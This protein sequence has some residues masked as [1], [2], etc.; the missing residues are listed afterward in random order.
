MTDAFQPFIRLLKQLVTLTPT[1]ETLIRTL[2]EPISYAK[3]T[4]LVEPGKVASYIYFI[5]D[6]F[7]RAYHYE[8]GNEITNH[9]GAPTGFITAYLSFS[10]KTPSDEA[11]E[12]L[13]PAQL[14]RIT[15]DNLDQL[16][17]Q[18]HNLALFGIVMADQYLVFNNQRSRDLIT[19]SAEQ[20]YQK[21]M[22]ETPVLLQH[23]PLQ[24][25]ASYIGVTPES[26]SRI[27]RKRPVNG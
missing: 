10:T 19:L 14:L 1:D 23:I 25:I 5:N 6:G 9:L 12:T 13:T 21:L 17:R 26:L 24:Y 18:S 11:V 8:D 20:R 16:Y 3:S 15:K 4:L 2:F 22:Q 27:R 7:A